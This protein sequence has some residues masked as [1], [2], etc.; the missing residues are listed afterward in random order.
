MTAVA[1]T[2]ATL[3]PAQQ[4]ATGRRVD[5]LD[6]VRAL[7]VITVLI[8]HALL[9]SPFP[10]GVGV[11]IFFVV[12]GYLVST[13]LLAEHVRFGSVHLPKFWARRFLRIGP[14]L[15]F[16][17]AALYPLGTALVGEDYVPRALLAAQF[18]SNLALTVKRLSISPLDHTWS[19]GQ[20]AQF[21]LAWPVLL[22]VLLALR[23]PRVLLAPG[24]LA[25]AAYCFR[26]LYVLQEADVRPT[27]DFR[28]EGRGGGLLIGCALAFVLA[29][30]PQLLKLPGSPEV[31]L[32]LLAG[33]FG[34]GT[35]IR[36]VDCSSRCR[37]RWRQRPCSWEVFWRVR[38]GRSRSCWAHR[39][40]PTW[41]E[42]RTRCTCGTTSSSRHSRSAKTCRSP[43]SWCS[44]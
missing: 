24:C 27:D 33:L 11:D 30:Q 39:P 29:W 22:V 8:V 20:E 6:G 13:L 25:G 37:S 40:S 36:P 4:V 23:V 44:R 41:D 15:L 17:L 18:R 19:L 31:G 16:M 32:L 2:P 14:P 35:L 43:W 5:A 9:T 42:S 10:G 38:A 34:Y 28:L 7:A 21:Y 12:S 26:A 1:P 3:A